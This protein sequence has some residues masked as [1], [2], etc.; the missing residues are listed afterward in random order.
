MELRTLSGAQ[1][2]PEDMRKGVAVSPM[3]RTWGLMTR[4]SE[5]KVR[6][7]PSPSGGM[8]WQLWTRTSLAK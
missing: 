7:M 5:R 6:Y 8:R 2:G 3:T 4:A 1:I